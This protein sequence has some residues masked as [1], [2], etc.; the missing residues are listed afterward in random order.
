MPTALILGASRGIGHEMV[1]QYRADGWRVIA[2]ARKQEDCDELAQ[3]GATAHQLDDQV[4]TLVM[5]LN[6]GSG[7]RGLA[8]MR[9]SGTVP[10]SRLPLLRPL[11][12]WRRA[13]L[14]EICAR[15]GGDPVMDPSNED[16][17]FE[18]VRVRCGLMESVW[19]DPA[20]IAA[21]AAN[22]CRAHSALNWASAREWDHNVFETPEEILYRAPNSPS[23]IRRRIVARAVAHLAT[24]GRGSELRGRELDRLLDVLAGGGQAT[25]RGVRCSGGVQW[26]FS[27]AP[28]RRR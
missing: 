5:R 17:Q 27:R 2:T 13:E 3:M 19:L 12:G 15:A 10:G 7:V 25:L 8:G 4:E 26:R 9:P 21:S 20:G 28:A 1:R 23:E 6:R 14:E 22:L 11:L 18:R 24:E 16:D